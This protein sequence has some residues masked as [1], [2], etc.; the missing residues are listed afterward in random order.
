VEDTVEALVRL[1]GSPPA[2]GAVVNVGNDQ[3][4]AIGDLAEL[5]RTIL[6]SSSSIERVPYGEA[7]GAG[8]ADLTRRRPDLQR[9]QRLT[10]FNP[11][12][13]METMVRR[14]AAG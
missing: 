12:T 13:T 2:R 1:L 14:L 6:G 9:L 3:P 5:V 4:I 11:G 7:Y 10:G 8:F